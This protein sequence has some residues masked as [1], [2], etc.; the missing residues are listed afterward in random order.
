M[1]IDY[2]LFGSSEDFSA[3]DLPRLAS[4]E[5]VALDDE[6]CLSVEGLVGTLCRPMDSSHREIMLSEYGPYGQDYNWFLMGQVDREVCRNELRNRLSRCAATLIS[7]R[8]DSPLALM[9]RAE[10]IYILNTPRE[11]F[12]SPICI[13]VQETIP[14]LLGR[15]YTKKHIEPPYS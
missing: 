8:P 12:V 5:G 3:I 7:F 11:L 1:S 14:K 9:C 6:G 15:P 10:S 13:D 4:I 2:F